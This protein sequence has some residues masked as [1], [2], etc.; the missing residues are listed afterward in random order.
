MKRKALFITSIIALLALMA[1]VPVQTSVHPCG[2]GQR[3]NLVLGQYKKYKQETATT[4]KL[5]E[6][7]QYIHDNKPNRLYIL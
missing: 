4:D 5:V 3:F 6:C 1:L 7:E 2:L